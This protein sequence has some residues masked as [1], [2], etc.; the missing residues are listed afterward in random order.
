M[1]SILEIKITILIT[2]VAF[3][4]FSL[5]EPIWTGYYL[6]NYV[7]MFKNAMS[8]LDVCKLACPALAFVIFW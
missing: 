8:A 4:I 1:K 3:Y 6:C 7:T 5:L 2:Y